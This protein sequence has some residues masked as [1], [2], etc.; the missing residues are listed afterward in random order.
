[1]AG[2]SENN[3]SFEDCAQGFLESLGSI[4]R[5]SP[6]T[7]RAYECDLEAFGSWLERTGF[8]A[9]SLTHAQLRSYL[10]ELSRA[11]Y[12]PRTVSRHLSALRGLYKWMSEHGVDANAAVAVVSSPKISRNL[13]KTLDDQEVEKILSTCN[14]DD[15]CGLRDAAFI[16]FMYATGARISEV[17]GLK[18]GDV[19]FGQGQARLFGK[20]SKER[21]VMLYPQALE[22]LQRYLDKARPALLAKRSQDGPTIDAVFLSV[23]GNAMS[24]DSLRKA[25][26]KHARA[27][28]LDAQVTPHAVRHTFATELLDGGADLRSVQ[29]LLGHASLSTTQIYTHVSVERLKQAARSAHPRS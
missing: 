14:M 15:P 23:R 22:V 17:A 8:D 25:F 1:M 9:F 3:L 7:L 11:G 2:G 13:P 24:A 10:G 16:E 21:L 5:L 27:A 6:N 19:D 12:S 26:E 18:L 28:G 4:R 20:G 29:E